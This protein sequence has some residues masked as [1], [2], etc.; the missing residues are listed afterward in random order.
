MTLAL[1]TQPCH[2]INMTLGNLQQFSRTDIHLAEHSPNKVFF[3]PSVYSY[4]AYLANRVA[5]GA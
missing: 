2:L 1:K 4:S 5:V 3:R